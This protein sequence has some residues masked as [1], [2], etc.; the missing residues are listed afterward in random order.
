MSCWEVGDVLLGDDGRMDVVLDGVVLRGQAEG[1][2]A[3]GEQHV[4]ALHPLLAADDIHRRE[5][6]GMADVQAL[7]GGI[8]ELD[9][10]VELGHEVIGQDGQAFHLEHPHILCLFLVQDLAISMASVLLSL[11]LSMCFSLL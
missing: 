7:A 9:Q 10:A 5:G 2:K 4:I 8:G 6:A 3:D 1:V 11:K